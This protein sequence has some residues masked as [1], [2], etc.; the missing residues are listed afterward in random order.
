MKINNSVVKNM[1]LK[2]VKEA[3]KNFNCELYSYAIMENHIHLLLY[4]R[5]ENMPLIMQYING[6]FAKRYN[7]LYGRIGPFWNNRYGLVIAEEKDDPIG[8]LKT[9]LIYQWYNP[10]KGNIVNNPFDYVYSSIHEYFHDDRSSI[11]NNIVRVN[12]LN[13]YLELGNTN[14]ERFLKLMEFGRG[15]YKDF[16]EIAV[17]ESPKIGRPRKAA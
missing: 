8:Y 6:N 11:P 13:V 17:Y 10:V 1:F 9:L 7:Q 12:L 4:P 15:I 14:S 3:M 16:V 2:V 5:E